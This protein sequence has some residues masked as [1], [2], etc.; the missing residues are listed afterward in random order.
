MR[1]GLSICVL[2][3][4]VLFYNK[5]A[6]KMIRE[7]THMINWELIFYDNGS[8]DGSVEWIE[9][10]T[11]QDPYR[12]RLFKGKGNSMRHGQ[13][14]D[15]LVEQ[16]QYNVCCTL[17][18]DAFPVSPRWVEP[19]FAL[20]ED[21]IVLSGVDRGWG[22]QL[23]HYV[24]PSYLFGRTEWLK[25]HTFADDWP[26]TDTGEQMGLDAIREG[27][28]MS[29]LGQKCETFDGRF[30]PKPVNYSDLVWHTWW[31]GRS[32]SVPGIVGGEVEPDYHAF[33]EQHLRERYNL[34]F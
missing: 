18:S 10:V 4:N 21:N 1:E 23:E 25:G 22:R 8:T 6:V 5:L 31:G 26:T 3:Y 17:C 2:T 24:C 33:I 7:L 12:V 29:L 11:Q 13:A 9:S 19:A 34:E 14:L 20:F 16:A 30:K 28:E 32:K 15:F 27:K